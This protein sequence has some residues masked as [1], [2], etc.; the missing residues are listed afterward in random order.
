[1]TMTT[2]GDMAGT[3]ANRLQTM[4]TKVDLTRL[5]AEMSSGRPAD[6]VSHLGGDT[7]R[8]ALIERDIGVAKA[9]VAAA[10]GLGQF[11]TTMQTVLDDV[12]TLRAG[13]VRQILPVTASSTPLELQRA[14][15]AGEAAFRDIVGRLNAS[16][17][18]TALFAGVATEG[19]AL[20]DADEM[21]ASLAAAAAGAVTA[22]DVI[23]AV[24]A[25]FD[26]PVGGFATMG[27]LGD[28]G[29]PLARRI[30][31][32]VTVTVTPRA[33]H[34]AFKDLLRSAAILALSA[35]PALALP[36]SSVATLVTGTLPDLLSATEPLTDL[37]AEVGLAEERTAEA[38]TRHGALAAALTIM[39]N[40][41]A[42]V[43]PYAT[44][45]ALKET[46]TQLQTQFLLTSRLSG[47]SLVNFLK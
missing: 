33:A 3:F 32:G 8:V 29:D 44:A 17:G 35:D 26:D 47:M 5:T 10:T 39:R 21:L 15:Q 46:E 6:I 13:L 23:A 7:A 31:E 41:L 42:L 37:R 18:E 2:I 45:L 28:T 38:A 9:R 36:A 27:Y 34:P 11:L 14:G 30:D 40:E 16:H 1:M 12:E 24:E 4:R 43:D 20:A 22:G 25:W 19:P